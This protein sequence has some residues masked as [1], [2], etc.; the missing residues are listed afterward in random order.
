MVL[1]TE[2]GMTTYG[3]FASNQVLTPLHA[4]FQTL[5]WAM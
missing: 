1:T 2:D 4:K 3:S 5:L